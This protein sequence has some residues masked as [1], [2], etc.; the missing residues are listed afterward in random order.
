M[1]NCR[2]VNEVKSVKQLG[3][4]FSKIANLLKNIFQNNINCTTRRVDE[5]K[6]LSP[7]NKMKQILAK[8]I[9]YK[10]VNRIAEEF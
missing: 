6:K 4:E 2:S 7:E 8:G 9:T 3:I 5:I 1:Q 10:N